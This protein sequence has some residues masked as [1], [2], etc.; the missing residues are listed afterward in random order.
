MN[1]LYQIFLFLHDF[2]DVFVG[3]GDLVKYSSVSTALDTGCLGGKV[4][5]RL[6]HPLDD[7]HLRGR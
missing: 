7:R 2:V 4:S 5:H 1:Y 3:P 6:S